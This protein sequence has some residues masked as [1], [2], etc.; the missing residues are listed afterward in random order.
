MGLVQTYIE[1]MCQTAGLRI[2]FLVFVVVLLLSCRQDS[3][4]PPNTGLQRLHY[5]NGTVH[6]EIPYENGKKHGWMRVFDEAGRPSYQALFRQ[7]VLVEEAHLDPSGKLILHRRFEPIDLYYAADSGKR[8]LREHYLVAVQKGKRHVRHGQYQSY[9]QNGQREYNTEYR[10]GVLDGP[11][12]YYLPSG[13]LYIQGQYREG[14]RH[15]P[16]REW[17]SLGHDRSAAQYYLGTRQGPYKEWYPQGTV[18]IEAQF[19]A[20]RREGK[21]KAYYPSGQIKWE[22]S[23]HQDRR[24]G[25]RRFYWEN[26]QPWI[27]AHY[28]SDS[29]DGPWEW[30]TRE[31]EPIS[32]RMYIKGMLQ[33]DSRMQEV[34]KKI[35]E[36][37]ANSSPLHYQG[38]FWTMRP[39]EAIAQA[40]YLE[41]SVQKNSDG[42]LEVLW[43]GADG[44][45][46]ITLSFND[47]DELWQIQL[48]FL[49]EKEKPYTYFSDKIERQLG[50]KFSTPVVLMGGGGMPRST[51]QKISWGTFTAKSLKNAT[52]KMH[53]P[54][55]MAELTRYEGKPWISIDLKSYL[56]QASSQ[57][58]SIETEAP[59]WS[60]PLNSSKHF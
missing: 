25:E 19:V 8:Q 27:L 42:V 20:G 21:A 7:D 51:I 30:W 3:N 28:T 53:Y 26:G 15:G 55:V 33:S 6:S 17:D 57:E 59:I 14:K 23:Y 32:T 2:S 50:G 1:K 24:E 41:A 10:D 29:L 46:K 9:Y 35:F 47:Y 60:Q 37:P 52:Q 18:A 36:A 58:N 39:E 54:V 44:T 12:Y 13:L 45:E 34:E 56:I 11:Y 49:N 4:P 38:F 16:W 40:R 43:D 31:G 22:G 5:P 48:N